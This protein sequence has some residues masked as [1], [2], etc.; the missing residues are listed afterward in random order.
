MAN[1][2][3][4]LKWDN[5]LHT[6]SFKE[7]G[8]VNFL[9][10]LSAAERARG[11]CAASAGNHALAL[12][13]YAK[14]LRIPCTLV[15]PVFAPLVK[16]QKSQRWG[17]EVIRHG[18]NFDEAYSYA[19]SLAKRT[20]KIYVPAFDH[21]RIIEGQGTAGLE[22]L[23]ELPD[24]DAVI[25]PIG[26]GGLI[27]GIGL[28]I[29]DIRPSV[30]IIG[31]RS[32]WAVQ[33]RATKSGHLSTQFSGTI[34]D[35]IAVKRNG[36]LT[37]PMMEHVVDKFITVSENEIAEA[38]VRVLE[39]ERTVLEGAGA[40]GIAALLSGKISNRFKKIAIMAC[41]SNIDMNML[42]RLLERDMAQQGRLLR[43]KVSLPDRP[44]S[45]QKVTSIL[46]AQGA[47]VLEVI[48]DR[49]FSEVPINVDISFVLEVR[50]ARHRQQILASLTE[51]GLGAAAQD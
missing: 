34:A 36:K 13:Y 5:K 41:G 8:A 9:S 23:Q 25:V 51:A 44:G 2:A 42:S 29:K 15:M 17:A 3:V 6:G 50:D 10:Q 19:E 40:A 33:A 21:L 22:I 47:N 31:V 16:V 48:H 26:G 49:S 30:Q 4:Y 18:S 45:L 11:V 38:V 35:G 7:R 28:A 32:E 24:V 43:L 39:L 1:G 14:K 12:S 46:A 37:I 27:S 20:K